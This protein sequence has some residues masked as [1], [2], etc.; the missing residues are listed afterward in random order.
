[1]EKR[2]LYKLVDAGTGKSMWRWFAQPYEVGK[3]Y[4]GHI[5]AEEAKLYVAELIN[6]I[7]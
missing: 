7:Q 2:Y 5:D 1:M 6:T 4:D 3:T